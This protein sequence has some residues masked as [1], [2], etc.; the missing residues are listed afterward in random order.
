MIV[1]DVVSQE[2]VKSQTKEMVMTMRQ[3]IDI[4]ERW[5]RGE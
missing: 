5:L 2:L 4:V 1:G 3:L